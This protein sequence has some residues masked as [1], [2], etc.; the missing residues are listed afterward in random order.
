M[1][2]PDLTRVPAFYHNCINQ[3]PDDDLLTAFRNQTTYVTD[4]FKA[5]PAN[6]IDYA[7]APGKW[8]IKESLQHVIDAERVFS[9]RALRFARKDPTPLPGF[10]ENLFTANS[11]ASGRSW[12]DLLAEFTSV[13]SASEWLF[14]S[15]DADQLES[16]GV[17][18]NNSIYVLGL[19]YVVVGHSLHHVR[20]FRER[21]L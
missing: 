10:D 8:T 17:S 21:Y 16:G 13:R 6:K 2:R 18:N 19:G 12:D 14:R 11:K 9:Y 4:F 20:L 15:F 5:I 7:Y 3:V 1:A